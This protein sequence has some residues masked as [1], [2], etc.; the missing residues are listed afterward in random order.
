MTDYR[1][2]VQG[3]SFDDQELVQSRHIENQP[4]GSVRLRTQEDDGVKTLL[5]H[6]HRLN[7]VFIE[8][9]ADQVI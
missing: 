8:Q 4:P 6:R 9:C 7:Y 1:S 5:L 2:S 3:E